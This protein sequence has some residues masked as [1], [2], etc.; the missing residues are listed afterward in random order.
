M[1]VNGSTTMGTKIVLVP[2]TIATG[3]TAYIIEGIGGDRG[4]T[5]RVSNKGY[6]NSYISQLCRFV[7]CAKPRS[8]NI[9]YYMLL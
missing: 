5:G 4:L 1:H 7:D 2:I 8:T 3:I 9:L 6:Q